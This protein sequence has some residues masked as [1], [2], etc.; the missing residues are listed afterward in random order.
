MQRELWNAG[1]EG[2]Q[3]T[4]HRQPSAETGDHATGQRL[5]DADA[6]RRPTPL[7]VVGPQRGTQTAAQHAEDHHAIDPL[8]RAA[9][10]ANHL[11]IAPVLGLQAERLQQMAAPA[12]E[13]AGHRP[14][15]AGDAKV[16]GRQ[17]TGRDH[18]WQRR[19]KPDQIVLLEALPIHNAS[20]V[21]HRDQFKG[22]RS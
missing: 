9:L 21:S 20:P 10:Q 22:G 2:S 1:E 11:E 13:L 8:Q 16:V 6:M 4:A 12:G 19:P 14:E 3:I 18:R 17:H 15:G 5:H 7:D